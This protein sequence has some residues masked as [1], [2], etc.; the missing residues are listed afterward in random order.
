MARSAVSRLSM[1]L[2]EGGEGAAQPEG[3]L[4]LDHLSLYLI[5][6]IKALIRLTPTPSGNDEWAAGEAELGTLCP[7]SVAVDGGGRRRRRQEGGG[8]VLGADG[9]VDT[10]EN[11]LVLHL[12]K[13][14]VLFYDKRHQDKI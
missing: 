7:V 5:Q 14:R 10:K 6:L 11:L 1:K 8:L 2:G 12:S 4:I 3:L 13:N 9:E